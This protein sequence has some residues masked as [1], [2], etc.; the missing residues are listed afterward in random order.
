MAAAIL[1]IGGALGIVSPG[2]K[3]FLNMVVIPLAG[4]LVGTFF[5]RAECGYYHYNQTN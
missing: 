5:G 1:L 3:D 2:L 4:F